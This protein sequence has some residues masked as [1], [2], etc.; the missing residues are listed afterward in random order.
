MLSNIS[1]KELFEFQNS[2]LKMYRKAI[3]SVRERFEPSKTLDKHIDA[4]LENL[5]T[6]EIMYD[7]LIKVREVC[8]EIM[9]SE[10]LSTIEGEMKVLLDTFW[11]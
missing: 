10:E 3:R 11:N 9:K 7:T 4:V 6:Y 1:S 2:T 8:S 5:E